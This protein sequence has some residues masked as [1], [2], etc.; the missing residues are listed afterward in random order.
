MDIDVL[1]FFE[2]IPGTFP[3][4]AAVLNLISTEFEG[5]TIKVQKTQISFSNRYNFAFVSLPA[6]TWKDRPA[7]CVILTFGLN[8][9][10]GDA[11]IF[12]A[13]EPY[14]GRW[15]HHVILQNEEEIDDQVKEWLH[16]AYDFSLNK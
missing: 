15:T 11:R 1:M 9:K 5:V 4:Y 7:V 14:P 6:R 12:R 10:L 8:R 16:E 3:L 2:R 13:V